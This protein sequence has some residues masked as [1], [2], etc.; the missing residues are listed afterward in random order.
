MRYREVSVSLLQLKQLASYETPSVSLWKPWLAGG[1]ETLREAGL[2][3]P[4][5]CPLELLLLSSKMHSSLQ[6]AP[7]QVGNKML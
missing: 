5:K 2:F 4:L 1:V 7:G 6:V 3:V